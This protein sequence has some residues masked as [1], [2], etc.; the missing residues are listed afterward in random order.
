MILDTA[1]LPSPELLPFALA[2]SL[3][4]HTETLAVLSE[5]GPLALRGWGPGWESGVWQLVMT[6]VFSGDQSVTQGRE[7]A[8]ASGQRGLC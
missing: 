3:C 1:G 6:L 8:V 2:T 5:Q 7:A 4:A